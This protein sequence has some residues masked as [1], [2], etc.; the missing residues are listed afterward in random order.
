MEGS[1]GKEKLSQ[2]SLREAEAAAE[3]DGMKEF[4]AVLRAGWGRHQAAY[5]DCVAARAA[6]V[7][8]LT[9]VPDGE[10]GRNAAL[11]L[12][13]CGDPAAK[14]LIEAEAK[15]HPQDSVLH[16]IFMPLVD[17]LSSLQKG[18]GAIAVAVLEPARRYELAAL[19]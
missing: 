9:E 12:A 5:G 15:L 4:A 8:S 13:Q 10:N 14:K 19:P 11:A 1:L 17:A 2:V 6:T 16:G 7:E 3:R 18:D